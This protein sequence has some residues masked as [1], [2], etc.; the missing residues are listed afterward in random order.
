M[1]ERASTARGDRATRTSPRRAWARW[2]LAAAF[3]L[4]CAAPAALLAPAPAAALE[5][6]KRPS[7]Y[8]FESWGA[9]DGLP[10][11]SVNAVAES[12]DGFLWLATF[13]GLA[14]F[15]GQRIVPLDPDITLRTGS[16][17]VRLW[18][19]EHEALWTASL[20]RGV[21]RLHGDEVTRWG[22]DQGLPSDTVTS[23]AG[24]PGG[25]VWVG[26]ANGAARR[27][28]ERFEA[29]PGIPPLAIRD[30]AF[31]AAGRPWVLTRSAGLFRVD[32]ADVVPVPLP[33][34]PSPVGSS[35][36]AT[37]DGGMWVATSAGLHRLDVEGRP[38]EH[39]TRA[40]GLAGDFIN[41]L[42][43]ARDGTLWIGFE[44]EGLQRMVDGRLERFDVA[45]GLPN[46]FVA[47]LY[48]DR[49]GSLWIGTNYGL[50]RLRDGPFLNL[51][52]REGLPS[53]FARVIAEDADGAIWV[54]VDDGGLARIVDDRIARTLGTADGLASPT[55]RALAA[56]PARG[57][58]W[59]AAYAGALHRIEGER[60]VETWGAR[61]GL[62]SALIRSLAVGPDG[63]LWIGTEDQGL[64]RLHD[65][66]LQRVEGVGFRLQDVRA[67]LFDR[68]GTLW[69]G[70][71]AHGLGRMAAGEDVVRPA[72]A[73]LPSQ[74]I[75][76]LFEDRGGRLWVGGQTGLTALGAAGEELDLSSLG[77]PFQ[78]A[79]FFITQDADG[80]LWFTGNVGLTRVPAASLEAL[81]AG[82]PG[83]HPVQRFDRLDGL[84]STQ[85]N[86]TSQPAGLLDRRGRLWV[87]GPR[88]VAMLD[89]RRT[90]RVEHQPTVR[91]DDVLVDG[92]DVAFGR[93]QPV[94]LAPGARLQ[95]RYAG[96]NALLPRAPLFQVRLD[97]LDQ[98]WGPA[99]ERDATTYAALPAGEYRFRVRAVSPRGTVGTRE[100]SLAFRVAPR[101]LERTDVRIG[102]VL[103]G[104]LG[105]WALVALRELRLRRT[106]RLLELQVERRTRELVEKNAALESAMGELQR[107]SRTDALTGL[108]NR[109]SLEGEIES[110]LALT[111]RRQREQAALP[112]A[113]RE[114]TVVLVIDL[115]HFKRI[116]DRHGHAAGDLVLRE[117][118]RELK[119][120]VRG[121]DLLVRWGGEE[122]LALLRLTRHRDAQGQALRLLQALRALRIRLE[123]G[124]S[125]GITASIGIAA[126]PFLPDAPEATSWAQVVELADSALYLAKERGRDRAYTLVPGPALRD[127]PGVA[128]AL[129][130][131]PAALADGRLRAESPGSG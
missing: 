8:I 102:G 101:L 44:G 83:P 42:M 84:R 39:L 58:L 15:D 61:E 71:Y 53:D 85:L 50:G 10:Q 94:D 5:P 27:V 23:I 104:L 32:G 88:G 29:V 54:G 125:V 121:S 52:L 33:G 103:L 127:A 100:A 113:E 21:A 24:K 106:T 116:N 80:D 35:L 96:V 81:E 92:A 97:G 34:E 6:G 111:R 45:D 79:V 98:D 110:E 86:G 38:R 13:E 17:I 123:D 47:T 122:F 87:P 26:T 4:A 115:D 72:P 36:V 49:Y 119:R 118:A 126:W 25:E 30:I 46:A 59:V 129:R 51:G 14:R 31:D 68:A 76:S 82:L 99:E 1:S 130:D 62:P 117:V 11:N 114:A 19:D 69:V 57:G 64:L 43:L 89:P 124:S 60:V 131:V 55:V 41:K 109:R 2:R 90:P 22:S 18:Q 3:A 91:I 20:D 63:T 37:E 56:D 70:S 66:R 16:A 128:D 12:P 78:R 74:R 67:L 95:V 107:L 75:M 7:Q 93:D 48:E 77:V 40:D 108:G 28:G 120:Q 105:L 73:V 65:G 9:D 112:H